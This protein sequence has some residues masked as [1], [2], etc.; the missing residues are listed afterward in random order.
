MDFAMVMLSSERDF[1][2]PRSAI[3]CGP[4]FATVNENGVDKIG[5]WSSTTLYLLQG[6]SLTARP[7]RHMSP[8]VEFGKRISFHNQLSCSTSCHHVAYIHF[9]CIIADIV[10]C[11]TSIHNES[12]IWKIK[13]FKS[14]KHKINTFNWIWFILYFLHL[15]ALGCSLSSFRLFSNS[16]RAPCFRRS[17]TTSWLCSPRHMTGPL[18]GGRGIVA[19]TRQL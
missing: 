3:C 1:S 5:C 11:N 15:P 18:L 10:I 6:S 2:I 19:R 8:F 13:I 16:L 14:K 7:E 17:E 4:G 12:P 9:G